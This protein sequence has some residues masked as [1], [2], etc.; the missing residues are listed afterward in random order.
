MT[1][2]TLNLVAILALASLAAAC[3]GPRN[4]MDKSVVSPTIQA[5]APL[6]D[7]VATSTGTVLLTTDLGWEDG[8]ITRSTVIDDKGG[9]LNFMAGSLTVPAGA[10]SGP[11]TFTVSFSNSPYMHAHFAAVGADGTPVSIFPVP[12][13]VTLS[14]ARAK[15]LPPNLAALAIYWVDNGSVLEKESSAVDVQGKK[16]S[17]Q[18]TH[19]TEYTPGWDQN[20]TC[21]PET[22]PDGCPL[23]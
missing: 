3:D 4:S 14:Y 23:P 18:V 17:A 2:R 19:F 13:T 6:A 12:L 5:P 22:S 15:G 9:R 11:T 21:D 10:V 16:I 1:R 20:P 8:E 7:G